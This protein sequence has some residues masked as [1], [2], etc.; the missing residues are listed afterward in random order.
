LEEELKVAYEQL[1]I[2]KI[3]SGRMK[4]GQELLTL[5]DYT[6]AGC[7]KQFGGDD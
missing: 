5:H 7:L 2:V 3:W 6:K 4:G 1:A